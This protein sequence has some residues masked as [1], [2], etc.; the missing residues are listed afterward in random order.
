MQKETE[1]KELEDLLWAQVHISY[2]TNNLEGIFFQ[3]TVTIIIVLNVPEFFL[4]Q[5]I[6]KGTQSQRQMTGQ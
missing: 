3:S 5:H 1:S 4:L 6:A 2:I